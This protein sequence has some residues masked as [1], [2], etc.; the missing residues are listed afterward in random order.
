[1][2]AG[3]RRPTQHDHPFHVARTGIEGIVEH[4]QQVDVLALAVG[5]VRRQHQPGAAGP[6]A[7]PE[8]AGP[9]PGEDDAVHGPDADRGQHRDDRLD[10]GRHVDRQ[11]VALADA[12]AAQPRR[13]PFDLGEQL[14]IGQAAPGTPF[15]ERDQCRL[16]APTGRHVAIERV[17][18]E[19]GPPAREP[20]E[21][22]RLAFLEGAVGRPGPVQALG[23]LEPEALGI[24]E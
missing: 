24:V 23:R 17:D 20:G 3:R 19:V 1:M 14:A 10:R 13:D 15:I 12:E 16:V 8:R 22:R 6:D 11:A 7:V 2:A 5:D 4:R 21:G 18:R 9:E